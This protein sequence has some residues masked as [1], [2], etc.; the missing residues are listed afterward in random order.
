M[1]DRGNMGL[2]ASAHLTFLFIILP[3]ACLMILSRLIK[4]AKQYIPTALQGLKGHE[5]IQKRLKV[6]STFIFSCFILFVSPAKQKK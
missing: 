4:Q 5:N 1:I 3:I 6:N 2:Y